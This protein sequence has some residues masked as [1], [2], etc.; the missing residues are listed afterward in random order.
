MATKKCVSTCNQFTEAECNPPRCKYVNG[1]SRKSYCRLSQKYKMSKTNCNITRKIK[2]KDLENV[3]KKR[4]GNFMKKSKAFLQV[5]CPNSGICT[6]FGEHT[7][8][9]NHFF[10][11]FNDFQ[12]AN[13]PIKAIGAVSANGFVKEIEYERQIYKAHAILKS[14]QNPDAWPNVRFL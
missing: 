7:K 9:L 5:V 8:E 14:A 3:A 13:S 2:K 11:G 10:K 1:Q 4:I 6:A 12:Y